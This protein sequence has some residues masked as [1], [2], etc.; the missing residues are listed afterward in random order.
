MA[1]TNRKPFVRVDI[2]VCVSE[3]ELPL[4]QG[5]TFSVADSHQCC[6]LW[7]GCGFEQNPTLNRDKVTFDI[8]VIQ[9][10]NCA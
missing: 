9:A 7:K 5:R 1:L 8:V 6:G 2:R 4:F 3:T 10:L